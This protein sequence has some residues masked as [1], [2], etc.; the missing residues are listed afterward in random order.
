M[1]DSELLT[2]AAEVQLFAYPA[3]LTIV[4]GTGNLVLAAVITDISH[5]AATLQVEAGHLPDP[6]VDS[7][8][9]LEFSGASGR[10]VGLMGRLREFVRREGG[11][12]VAR[13]GFENIHLPEVEEIQALRAS[14]R[15]DQRL[16]WELWDNL[17]EEAWPT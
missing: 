4:R 5:A 11:Q 12:A 7:R 2:Q 8:L 10:K 13:V 9:S 1:D 14:L 16:L 17:Q 3:R 15:K 6:P